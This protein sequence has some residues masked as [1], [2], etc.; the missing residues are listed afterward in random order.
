[1]TG[2]ES[3]FEKLVRE[4][5]STISSYGENFMEVMCRDASDGHDV[6]RVGWTLVELFHE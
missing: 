4:N 5:V 2:K 3:E 6:G 1:M